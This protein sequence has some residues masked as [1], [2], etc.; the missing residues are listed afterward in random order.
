MKEPKGKCRP[1]WGQGGRRAAGSGGRPLGG[2]R[3]TLSVELETRQ[4]FWS[5]TQHCQEALGTQNCEFGIKE[6][7][8]GHSWLPKLW[9]A[10]AP[11]CHKSQVFGLSPG[12]FCCV[13]RITGSW[14]LRCTERASF[15]ASRLH[16]KP[17]ASSSSCIGQGAQEGRLGEQK[18]HSYLPAGSG[19]SREHARPQC[20]ARRQHPGGPVPAAGGHLL[21]AVPGPEATLQQGGV[22][23]C[24]ESCPCWVQAD[25]GAGGKAPMRE[26][27]GQRGHPPAT[28]GSW[29]SGAGRPLS[30]P[31]CVLS[32][33]KPSLPT[34]CLPQSSLITLRGLFTITL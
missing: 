31:P 7:K 18:A 26:G 30:R 8:N 33:V 22:L 1:G 14:F 16:G 25:P 32:A 29:G 3:V 12:V 5:P 28:A 27:G 9:A 20:Q 11:R 10:K 2:V 17:P 23:G 6:S 19:D 21:G 24:G 13:A 34:Y 4:G 15:L